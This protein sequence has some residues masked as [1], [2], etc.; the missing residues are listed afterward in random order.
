[1]VK[2]IT[3]PRHPS[4]KNVLKAKRAEIITWTAADLEADLTQTGF[5][6]SPTQ[7]IQ[8]WP[9]EKRAGGQVLEG[10]P[11][12]IAGQLAEIIKG[13]QIAVG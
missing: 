6:G 8:V 11:D 10:E 2:Q 7:V 1:V 9:P 5:D 12:E 4:M 13:M 3:A